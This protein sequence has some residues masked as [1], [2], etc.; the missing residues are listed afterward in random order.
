MKTLKD[1]SLLQ[2][3]FYKLCSIKNHITV[4]LSY[5][6]TG[7]Q[8]LF[9]H[10]VFQNFDDLDKA[11][12]ERVKKQFYKFDSPVCLYDWALQLDEQIGGESEAW[13][14]FHPEEKFIELSGFLSEENAPLLRQRMYVVL[15]SFFFRQIS[16]LGLNGVRITARTDGNLYKVQLRLKSIYENDH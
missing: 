5:M 2:R 8:K 7:K 11:L 13:L 9:K 4:P 15:Q 3:F 10:G 12:N 6:M 16:L 1:Y 14:K